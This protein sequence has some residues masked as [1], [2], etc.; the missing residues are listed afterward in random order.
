MVFVFF[1]GRED[2][3][4]PPQSECAI[5]ASYVSISYICVIV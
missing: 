4:M 2:F 5:T 3:C 1:F